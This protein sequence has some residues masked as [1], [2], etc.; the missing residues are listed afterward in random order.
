MSNIRSYEERVN[1][2]DWSISEK[3]LGYNKNEVLNIG[4]SCSDRICQL[5]KAGKTALIWEG[6]GGQEKKFSYNDI[7][8][9]SN[10]IGAF[11]RKLG[12]R[13]EDRVCI[14]LDRIL[15]LRESSSFHSLG[16]ISRT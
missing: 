15:I 16:F 14:F 9:A 10:T 4:W 8:L 12:I 13:Q 2:F 7:R 1:N 5:G 6:L 11:L 3:E